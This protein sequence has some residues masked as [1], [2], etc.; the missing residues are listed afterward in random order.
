VRDNVTGL[1]WQ[2]AVPQKMNWQAA[3]QYCA[4]LTLA[5]ESDWRLPSRIELV[6]L[7]DYTLVAPSINSDAFP[8]TPIDMFSTLTRG[9]GSG[10]NNVREVSFIYGKTDW[11][12]ED[13]QAAVRCVRAEPL[14]GDAK[15]RYALTD[16]TVL[17]TG[18][19]L[20]WERVF[21]FDAKEFY[22]FDEA[23]AHCDALTL[24]G[25]GDWR[26]PS[27]TELQTLAFEGKYN[28]AIDPQAFPSAT[29]DAYDYWSSSAHPERPGWAFNVRFSDGTSE[30][31]PSD[32]GERVLC[33]R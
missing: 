30:S 10:A 27:I 3:T 24:G 14:S 32:L 18:T 4:G 1:Q 28:P 7:V 19:G 21:Q 8:D 33:V 29:A 16:E 2:R 12:T 22:T 11:M 23:P 31:I 17:D 15:P 6:S 9:T 5:G 25:F 20:V 26:V 13:Y